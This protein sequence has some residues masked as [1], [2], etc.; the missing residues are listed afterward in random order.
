MAGRIPRCRVPAA[1]PRAL[2]QGHVQAD[3]PDHLLAGALS[4]PIVVV[5]VVV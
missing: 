2:F 1:P 4:P 3:P 5:V